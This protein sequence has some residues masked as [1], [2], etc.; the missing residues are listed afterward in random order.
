M[1]AE[2][3]GT[4]SQLSVFTIALLRDTGYYVEVNENISEEI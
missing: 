4:E 3:S 1:T 2:S